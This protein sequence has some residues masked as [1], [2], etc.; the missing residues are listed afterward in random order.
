MS[1]ESYD[2][3]LLEV[4]RRAP[5]EPVRLPVRSRAQAV[6]L[7][8][9]LYRLRAELRRNKH[10]LS[11]SAERAKV[12]IVA[13]TRGLYLV[14]VSRA[15]EEFDEALRALGAPSEP[16]ARE[17]D[18]LEELLGPLPEPKRSA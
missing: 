9:R 16:R 7:R 17:S 8:H 18:P 6:T 11:H 4:W 3:R 12:S 5:I 10:P 15:D 2:P 1:I 13:H 14:V